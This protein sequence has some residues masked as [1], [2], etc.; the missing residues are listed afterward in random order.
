MQLDKHGPHTITSEDALL[1]ELDKICGEGI[2]VNDQE[3]ALDLYAIAAPLCNGEGTVVAAV[4]L[5]AHSSATSLKEMVDALGPGLIATA[6]RI[7][8]LQAS[9][10]GPKSAA[11]RGNQI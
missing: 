2:A 11:G 3:F 8:A 10:F 1:A 5:T 7:S 9:A 4:S 6:D